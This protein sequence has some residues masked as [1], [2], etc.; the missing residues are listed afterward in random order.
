MSD[1]RGAGAPGRV[2]KLVGPNTAMVDL[3]PWLH[4]CSALA[5]CVCQ[6]RVRGKKEGTGFLVGPDA[7]LTNHHVVEAALGAP[8][9]LAFVFDY[10][11]AV[12][13]EVHPG[14]RSPARRCSPPRRWGRRA[15]GTI[16]SW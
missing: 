1:R 8:G 13:G 7:V 5:S 4:R 12:T 10:A 6:V 16:R 3:H 9:E 14:S 11:R 15:S 2:E